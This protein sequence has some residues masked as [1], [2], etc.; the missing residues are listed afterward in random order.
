MGDETVHGAH[1]S[2]NSAHCRIQE[3]NRRLLSC[4]F[5]IAGV[6]VGGECVARQI[7]VILG[8]KMISRM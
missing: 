8:E 5:H 2:E 1:K 7:I 3:N 4:S 6:G